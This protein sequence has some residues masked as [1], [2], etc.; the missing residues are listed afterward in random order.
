M[1]EIIT[2]IPYLHDIAWMYIINNNLF[3][4]LFHICLYKRQYAEH[5]IRKKNYR[6]NIFSETYGVV[7]K[8]KMLSR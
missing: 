7:N 5:N 4:Y 2:S 1:I 8:G 6:L 3:V